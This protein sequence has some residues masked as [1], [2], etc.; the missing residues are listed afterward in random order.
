MALEVYDFVLLVVGIAIFGVVLLPRFIRQWPISLP[1]FHL[2]FGMA[3]F[4]FPLVVPTPDPIAYGTY[5]EHLTEFGVIIAL[6]STG[7]KIDRPL[8]LKRWASTW[9]LLGIGMPFT[10][11]LAALLGWGVVGFVLPTAILLGA[12]I[13]PTDPDGLRSDGRKAR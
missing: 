3:I 2:L 4:S 12:V 11:A 13:A 5:T 8:G 9:R 7:L 10:I 6:M 1:I